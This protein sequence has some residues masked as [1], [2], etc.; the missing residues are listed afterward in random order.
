MTLPR[1]Q[2]LANLAAPW[3]HLSSF[4]D[5]RRPTLS[6]ACAIGGV[7]GWRVDPRQVWEPRK[8]LSARWSLGAGHCAERES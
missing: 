7:S 4:S 3:S 8:D 6:P 2:P 1:L 5:S